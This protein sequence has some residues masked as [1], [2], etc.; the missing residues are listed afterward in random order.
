[1]AG[2]IYEFVLDPLDF[3]EF[4]VFRNKEELIKKS[5]LFQEK[6]KKEFL[7][8]QKRQFIEI[9]NESE[10]K[11]NQ[12]V[13]SMIEKIIYLDIPSIFPIEQEDLL[14]KILKIVAS[15]PGLLS[16]YESLS[17]ELGISRITL[18]NYFYYLEEAFLIK[19]LYNFSR[20]MLISEKN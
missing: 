3:E 8:Y 15:N 7:V 2:R 10:E 18:S 14:L 20:N 11:I 4:L 12:Y 9:V 19:K 17:K 16:D 5:D 13:K 1:M 6:I